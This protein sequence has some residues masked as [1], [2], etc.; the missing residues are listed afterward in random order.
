MTFF[1]HLLAHKNQNTLMLWKVVAHMLQ[2]GVVVTHN[3]SL[4][5]L[6]DDGGIK[7]HI[8]Y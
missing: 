8:C 2:I 7:G 3:K 5:C 4:L 1:L 6:N